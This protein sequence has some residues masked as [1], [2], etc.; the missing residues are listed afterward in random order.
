MSEMAAPRILIIDDDKDITR[1]FKIGLE[2]RGFSISTYN[3]AR[4]AL[5]EIQPDRYD[6]ALL[7][8]RMPTM[9]GHELY[10]KFR[11]CDP[12][13]KVCF[14]TAADMTEKDFDRYHLDPMMKGCITKPLEFA[15]LV[16]RINQ[17]LAS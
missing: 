4:V 5:A 2:R 1:V 8:L 16:K 17:A 7:D 9:S 3:D 15:E 14:L 11:E 10:E 6:L 12:R 13:A